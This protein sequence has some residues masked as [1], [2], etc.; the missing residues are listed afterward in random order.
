M[1]AFQTNRSPVQDATGFWDDDGEDDGDEPDGFAW[2]LF[3][4]MQLCRK[5]SLKDWLNAN[6]GPRSIPRVFAIFRQILNGVEYVH[7]QGLMHR[8][9]KPSNIFFAPDGTVKIGDFGLATTLGG[10]PAI[11]TP[12]QPNSAAGLHHTDQVGTQLYMSPEQVLGRAYDYKVDIY[13]LGI[14]LFE[15]LVPFSTQMERQQTL[16]QVRRLTF[17][18][19]FQRDQPAEHALL[20]LMLS[21]EPVLRPSIAE[22]RRSA[23]R[24]RSGSR[25][26]GSSSGSGSGSGT[27]GLLEDE[28]DTGKD[29]T[30]L[31]A[32]ISRLQF[33]GIE[34]ESD[35]E[36]ESDAEEAEA[37]DRDS[38][39]LDSTGLDSA[40]FD[41]SAVES[42]MDPSAGDQLKS[43]AM[44]RTVSDPIELDPESESESESRCGELETE[45][46]ALRRFRRTKIGYL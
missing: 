41:V 31:Q 28:L 26:P 17:P 34:S 9:L 39:G 35:S 32:T 18:A 12:S 43:P 44:N 27:A 38:I 36:A 21:H 40:V 33:T 6:N 29:S 42:I 7:S 45:G 10:D 13:S 19:T 5:E 8:D 23:A 15:L 20:A 22:I 3:I 46:S 16:V 1:V 37:G 2:Y 30:T 25:G 14:I 4:Q 11:H 24:C